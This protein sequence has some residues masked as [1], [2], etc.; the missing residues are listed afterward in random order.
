MKSIVVKIHKLLT[1][2]PAVISKPFL[3]CTLPLY[4]HVVS[5]IE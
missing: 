1:Y 4:S 2:T 3:L 5:D